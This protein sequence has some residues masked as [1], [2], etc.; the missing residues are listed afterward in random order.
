MSVAHKAAPLPSSPSQPFCQP[1]VSLE[2]PLLLRQ[3]RRRRLRGSHA[4]CHIRQTQTLHA[5]GWQSRPR[6]DA[7]F[8]PLSPSFARICRIVAKAHFSDCCFYGPA[9][10]HTIESSVGGERE[11][12]PMG[13]L[14]VYICTPRGRELRQK[15]ENGRERER[16]RESATN[17][18]C[19]SLG[20]ESSN[21]RLCS[22]PLAGPE[23]ANAQQQRVGPTRDSS[24]CLSHSR[25]PSLPN[26]PSVGPAGR[27][28]IE[29]KLTTSLTTI[30]TLTN[31]SYQIFSVKKAIGPRI[32]CAAHA[33]KLYPLLSTQKLSAKPNRR[34]DSRTEN[35]SLEPLVEDI[36]RR[37]LSEAGEATAAEPTGT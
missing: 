10:A 6:Y 17:N 25:S 9:H 29:S 32:Y 15:E 30:T 12:V 14:Y 36:K 26:G 21:G 31:K 27:E 11:Q 37:R 28:Q 5:E 35:V 7:P 2:G 22:L 3:A 23:K 16:D 19:R 24:H 13:A 1:I 4:Q 34:I 20:R 18:S 8:L 33:L